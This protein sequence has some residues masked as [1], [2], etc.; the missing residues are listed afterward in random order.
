MMDEAERDRM[1]RTAASLATEKHCRVTVFEPM[2]NALLPATEPAKPIILGPFT[3]GEGSLR[4]GDRRETMFE[5]R[6]ALYEPDTGQYRVV[7]YCDE[8][9][10]AEAIVRA[11]NE[12]HAIKSG[13]ARHHAKL[14]R[15]EKVADCFD[16]HEVHAIVMNG[17]EPALAS[18]IN[19]EWAV[20]LAA[21]KSAI[22][23]QEGADANEAGEAA[24]VDRCFTIQRIAA[25]AGVQLAVPLKEEA[26]RSA[27]GLPDGP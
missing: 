13:V 22:H 8:H 16:Y 18:A 26:L 6:E 14:N 19:S 24:A 12:L 2:P 7:A 11:F 3:I 20:A 10:D 23:G 5:V 17:G 21:L 4:I 9:A 15:D 27:L 25:A 1:Y